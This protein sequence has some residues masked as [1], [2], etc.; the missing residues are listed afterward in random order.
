MNYFFEWD[1]VKART[2]IS[3]HK[4]SFEKATEIFRDPLALTIY[5]NEHSTVEDRWIT[6]GKT[7]S[8][9]I[10]VVVHTFKKFNSTEI[11]IRIISA[12]KATENE[13]KNYQ[14]V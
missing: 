8:E 1:S 11:H 12:R 2:N 6:L 9:T 7:N 10:L 4:I 13:L 5:D 14:G 3:K